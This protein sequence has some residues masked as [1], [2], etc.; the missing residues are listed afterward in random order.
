MSVVISVEEDSNL[1]S[2]A[3]DRG[4]LSN[5]SFSPIVSFKIALEAKR[6]HTQCSMSANK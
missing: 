4:G 2:S 6:R 5:P 3:K 1:I